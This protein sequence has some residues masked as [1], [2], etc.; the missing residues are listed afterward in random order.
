MELLP[1]KGA[2]CCPNPFSI[3]SIDYT[4]YLSL[5]ARNI[6]IAESM[7]TDI[8]TVCNGCFET[9]KTT[10]TNL[11]K[12]EKLRRQANNILS[13]VGK[14][15]KGN[16]E[17]KHVLQVFSEDIGA[18]K[19]KDSVI[20]PLN[21]LKVAVHYGCHILRPSEL[22]CVDNSKKPLILDRITEATGAE[23]VQYKSKLLCCG[24]GIASADENSALSMA[25][26]KLV[27][28]QQAGADC[29]VLLCPSCFY[30]YDVIQPYINEKFGENLNMP[31][32]YYQQLLGIAMGFPIKELGFEYHQVDVTP[33]IK[34]V[35]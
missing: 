12:H 30:Q 17:I 25:R 24:A 34:K 15:F 6:C 28:I 35:S 5:A 8:L 32:L 13:S 31:V 18:D 20:K 14:E 23:T 4:T 3:P 27:Q 22:L 16:I 33:V 26:E 29:I 10:N 1:L 21:G 7:G 9:L 11:K 2:G 19:I